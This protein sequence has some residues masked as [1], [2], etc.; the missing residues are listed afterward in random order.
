M[1]ASSTAQGIYLLG[2]GAWG[3][4]DILAPENDLGVP[5]VHPVC[6]PGL[7]RA[8]AF[9]SQESVKGSEPITGG[10]TLESLAGP[11]RA[12]NRNQLGEQTTCLVS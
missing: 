9:E 4:K 10:I 5:V 6:R 8:K 1:S 7:V 3:V 2:S 11:D 12:G